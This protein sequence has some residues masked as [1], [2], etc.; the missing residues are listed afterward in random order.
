MAVTSEQHIDGL[1]ERRFIVGDIPGILWLPAS[2][3][4]ARPVPLVL[5]GQPGGALPLDQSRPRI[6]ERAQRAAQAGMAT[7][8]LELPG[9]EA[10]PLPAD[11]YVARAELRDAV[12]TRTPVAD[13]L[14]DRLVLPL[15]EVAVP[16]AQAALDVLLGLP[17]LDAA[18]GCSG[19][20]ISIGV[21]L[22]AVDPRVRAAALFA[23]SFVPR[24][25]VDVARRVT[26]PLYVLLQ[27]DDEGNDR[28]MALGLFDAFASREKTLNA[29]MGGHLG[30]PAHAGDEATRFLARHLVEVP[31]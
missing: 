30:V 11:W 9:G 14:V 28:Q 17:E 27:W 13:D 2:A 29:N 4:P 24:A 6:L 25:I 12:T 26:I 1:I 31:A 8:T 7:A 22:A 23:G 19:G 3:R 21:Q 5:A 16:E 10:R 18:V 20:V 15:V